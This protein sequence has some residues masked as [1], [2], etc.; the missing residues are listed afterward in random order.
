LETLSELRGNRIMRMQ[1]LVNVAGEAAPRAVHAVQHTLYPAARLA[2]W[3]DEDRRTR[4]VFIGRELDER[5]T[6]GVL[7]SFLPR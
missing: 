3:P 1:G 6:A 7:E 2:A 4:I 5:E